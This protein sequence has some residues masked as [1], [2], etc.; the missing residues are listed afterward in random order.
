MDLR[1]ISHRYRAL[2]QVN[3]VA[4]TRSTT[5]ELFGALCAA[6]K[7]L[8]RYDQAG[9][10]LYD[11]YRDSLKIVALYGPQQNSIFRLGHL[12]D[13]K[14]SQT[15]WV[16][17]HQAYIIRR[18]LAKEVLFPADKLTM[19]EGYRSICSVPLLI[20]H[21]SSIGVVSV[22]SA[23]KGEFSTGDARIV[24]ELS[25]QIALAIHC[26]IP[27]CHNHINTK[28]VC[29]RC[30]GAAGGKTTVSKHRQNLSDWGKRGGRGRKNVKFLDKDF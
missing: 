13:R 20:V 17:E 16:F 28:L 22:L 30:I 10:S 6:L 12:L 4:L 7:R 24:Q 1:T 11:H 14:T 15:G 25:N 29:P 2:L 23:R 9:L 18:D 8:L 19:N 21:G 27:R 3:E 5:E 26:V